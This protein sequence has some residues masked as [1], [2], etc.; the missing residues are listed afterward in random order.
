VT[1]S[2][3]EGDTAS[4]MPTCAGG[5]GDGSVGTRAGSGGLWRLTPKR[6]SK[7]F[8]LRTVS[9]LPSLLVRVLWRRGLRERVMLRARLPARSRRVGI[10]IEPDIDDGRRIRQSE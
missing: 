3:A 6:S 10:G 7:V 2:A 4:S 8:G 1:G 9:G 5:G